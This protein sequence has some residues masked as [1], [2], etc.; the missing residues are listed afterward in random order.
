MTFFPFRN[1]G[2]VNIKIK[3]KKKKKKNENKKVR[4]L[5]MNKCPPACGARVPLNL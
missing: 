3:K 1:G 4:T 2:N 5:Y